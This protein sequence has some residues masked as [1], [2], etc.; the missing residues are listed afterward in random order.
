MV[1][2]AVYR[3][4]VGTYR[5]GPDFPVLVAE[6]KKLND[7]EREL[8]VLQDPAFAN[9]VACLRGLSYARERDATEQLSLPQGT[10]DVL[11]G[12]IDDRAAGDPLL[13]GL[14]R[15]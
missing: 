11:L 4:E 15:T 2:G 10:R 6:F 5:Q 8:R 3:A 1:A 9:Q 7:Q 14:R 13:A 12:M